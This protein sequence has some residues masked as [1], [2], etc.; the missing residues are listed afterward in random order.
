MYYE[1][2]GFQLSINTNSRLGSKYIDEIQNTLPIQ[3]KIGSQDSWTFTL[4]S[5]LELGDKDNFIKA[6]KSSTV[7]KLIWAWTYLN[8]INKENLQIAEFNNAWRTIDNF[9]EKV[10]TKFPFFICKQ[11]NLKRDYYY[12]LLG[13]QVQQVIIQKIIDLIGIIKNL[14]HLETG[15][16]TI[17]A[18]GIEYKSKGFLFLGESGAGKTTISKLSSFQGARVL[19]DDRILVIRESQGVY[20]IN[21]SG[22][23]ELIPLNTIFTI[24]KDVKDMLVPLSKV[25]MARAITEGF[26]QANLPPRNNKNNL[27]LAFR[28]ASDIARH[29]N[30]YELH[31][32]KSFNF[33]K[34]IDTEFGLD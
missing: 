25:R 6:P 14:W 4:I 12:F 9:G 30:C 7:N 21:S 22:F 2:D 33:R 34:Q 23:P 26:L 24:V 5:P 8:S 3:C 18:S 1:K 19:N 10:F 32:R 16:G 17:H 13:N 27:I 29:V 20:S 28:N 31:F 11:D 15:G